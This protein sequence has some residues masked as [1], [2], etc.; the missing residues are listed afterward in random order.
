MKTLVITLALTF[1]CW[2][3]HPSEAVSESLRMEYYENITLPCNFTRHGFTYPGLQ[4]PL[5]RY[6]ILPNATVLD[7]SYPGDSTYTVIKPIT[8]PSDFWLHIREAGNA[9]FGV[10]HCVMIWN[11]WDYKLDAIRVAL[12]EEGPYYQRKL[13]EFELKVIIGSSVAGGIVLVVLVI[14]VVCLCRRRAKAKKDT[15][16]NNYSDETNGRSNKTFSYEITAGQDAGSNSGPTVSNTSPQ[17][18][19]ASEPERDP[20]S[21]VQK[22]S[23][24]DGKRQAARL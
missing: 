13:E 16:F 6:W 3:L 1:I 11:N 17:T 21:K 20:Y 18:D 8:N 24:S 2:H 22:G 15:T 4:V 7:E 14:C 12:N 9:Q 19:Q 10:Y 23:T 5:R